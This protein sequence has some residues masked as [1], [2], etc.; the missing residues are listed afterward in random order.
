MDV[1]YHSHVKRIATFSE[2]SF[3]FFG[4]TIFRNDLA[5]ILHGI[6]K[7]TKIG[8]LT[9][10]E[11]VVSVGMVTGTVVVRFY[12]VKKKKKNLK[13]NVPVALLLTLGV[14]KYP[15][16]PISQKKI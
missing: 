3:L 13:T 9:F 15:T 11:N 5:C 2:F 1:V 4:D 16:V 7:P 14:S 10:F 6:R 12:Q 8:L